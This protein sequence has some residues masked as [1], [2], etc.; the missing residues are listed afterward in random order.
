VNFGDK[1]F[2][3]E[4]FQDRTARWGGKDV[5]ENS[6]DQSARRIVLR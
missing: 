2:R 5:D 6:L 1:I 3:L 4:S